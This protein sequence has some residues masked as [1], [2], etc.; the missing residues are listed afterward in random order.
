MRI[1][2]LTI[3][4]EGK[5]IGGPSIHGSSPVDL[6][7]RPCAEERRFSTLL[8][9]VQP[10]APLLKSHS[11]TVL[12]EAENGIMMTIKTA[13]STGWSLDVGAEKKCF[14]P[15][16]AFE[17]LPN[18]ITGIIKL[19][20]VLF[21]TAITKMDTEHLLKK[22][23]VLS[24]INQKNLHPNEAAKVRMTQVSSLEASFG[25]CF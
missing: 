2:T 7:I 20:R 14:S 22:S 25:L 19:L 18:L 6:T 16:F 24:I 23:S 10:R 21:K 5:S 15:M 13:N 12:P 17:F 1:F 3:L 8:F 9:A 11:V 4:P